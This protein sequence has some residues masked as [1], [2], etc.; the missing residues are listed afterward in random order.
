MVSNGTVQVANKKYNYTNSPYQLNLSTRT[1]IVQCFLDTGMFQIQISG[2]EFNFIPFDN[3]YS[4]IGTK[5]GIDIVC[6]VHKIKGKYLTTL[7]AFS[8]YLYYTM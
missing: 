8:L 2:E 1:K 6:V 5:E 7:R 4:H 3:L